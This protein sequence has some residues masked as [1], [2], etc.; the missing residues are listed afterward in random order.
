MT[1][2]VIAD[3]LGGTAVLKRKIRNPSDLETLT[4]E[5]LPSQIL[6][7]LA[8]ELSMERAEV[9]RIVGISPRT[10]SRRLGVQGRFSP[11]ES[12]RIMR[13][14]RVLARARTTLGNVAK[15]S[16]WLQ[17]PNRVLQ[18]RKPVELLDTDAGVQSVEMLLGW[19]AYGV[20]S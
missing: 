14:A 1:V 18:G 16:H 6:P 7:R 12:D 10:L 4:R 11:D 2:A 5:G 9:A 17:T 3:V 15:A 8:Q 19:I 20:Y 13:F